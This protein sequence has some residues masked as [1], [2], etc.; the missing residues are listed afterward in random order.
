MP[1]C[2]RTHNSNIEQNLASAS[3]R[4]SGVRTQDLHL[5]DNCAEEAD[6]QD[7]M[8]APIGTGLPGSPLHPVGAL[9]IEP[10]KA[11]RMGLTATF[12]TAAR[13]RIQINSRLVAGLSGIL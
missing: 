8:P 2:L 5:W 3:V 9:G 12:P 11:G 10:R 1:G 7:V 13:T 4:S 6:A